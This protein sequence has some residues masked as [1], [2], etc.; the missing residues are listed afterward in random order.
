MKTWR[1]L[2]FVS[3]W[4]T[5]VGIAVAQV[6][7]L[8]HNFTTTATMP[9]GGTSYIP[10]DLDTGGG[11]YVNAKLPGTALSAGSLMVTDSTTTVPNTTN[12][13]FASNNFKVGGS[14]G[15]AT[16][17]P[18]G[19]VR[20][21][22]SGSPTFT[23]GDMGGQV[24]LNG[25]SIPFT[26]PAIG[27]GIFNTGV[28]ARVVNNGLTSSAVTN[29][30]PV[31]GCGPTLY[32]GGHFQ[33]ISN[34][35]SLDCSG[36]PGFGSLLASNNQWPGQNATP[37]VTLTDGNTVTVPAAG[38]TLYRI[39]LTGA[40]HLIQCPT[41]LVAGQYPTFDIT[42]GGSGG[43]QP[44]WDSCFGFSNFTPPTLCAW[45]NTQNCI[46]PD[47]GG[48]SAVPCYSVA[49][50]GPAALRCSVSIPS[51][52]YGF[53]VR[54]NHVATSSCS[55][56]TTCSVTVTNSI[57]GDLRLL[58]IHWGAGV[59]PLSTDIV[60]ATDQFGNTCSQTTGTF[61][62]VPTVNKAETI[63][64]CPVVTG[65]ASSTVTVTFNPSQSFMA[66]HLVEILG[67]ASSFDAGIGHV[68]TG[69]GNNIS[70]T[71]NGSLSEPYDFAFTFLKVINSLN[72]AGTLVGNQTTLDIT[73]QGSNPQL[74]EY[75][76]PSAN[77]GTVTNTATLSGG[78]GTTNWAASIVVFHHR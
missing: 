43:Y 3:L 41:N 44:V 23:S 73:A 32:P 22:T 35:T 16:V 8:I 26:V 9:L 53:L 42:Q 21:A 25:V 19:P 75:Q 30:A 10:V 15:S 36:F 27:A 49:T 5:L 39:T 72:N 57:A 28:G 77:S 33:Y 50:S 78:T 46:V 1:A 48:V 59:A 76:T 7:L 52:G 18:V 56:S 12:L 70:V 64:A 20:T 31:N 6:P 29:T 2:F 60:S 61:G 38:S 65:A 37:P 24:N 47:V 51:I 14:G 62:V 55:S 4:F 17:S 34:G 13:A 74:D 45:N 69:S 63:Y 58:G 68:A 71:S 54:N 66:L 67:G 11:V 40:S